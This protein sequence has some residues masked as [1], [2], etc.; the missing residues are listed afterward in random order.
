MLIISIIDDK[1]SK[2]ISDYILTFGY[3]ANFYH[4]LTYIFSRK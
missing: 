1:R 4:L 3:I 2:V